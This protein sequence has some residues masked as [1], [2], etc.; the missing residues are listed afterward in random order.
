MRNGRELSNGKGNE[1]VGE[2]LEES[3]EVIII[4]YSLLLADFFYKRMKRKLNFYS[5]NWNGFFRI[6]GREMKKSLL[7]CGK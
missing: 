2:S 3:L 6:G 4:L 5:K 7:Q 1:R